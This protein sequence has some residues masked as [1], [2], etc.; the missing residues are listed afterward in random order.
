MW[1]AFSVAL[2]GI[3]PP[4]IDKSY[5]ISSS[6]LSFWTSLTSGA[7][8]KPTARFS[9]E[10]DFGDDNAAAALLADDVQFSDMVD[11]FSRHFK[12]S[13]C[14]PRR[15]RD[16]VHAGGVIEFEFDVRVLT[17]HS[18]SET[19]SIEGTAIERQFLVHIDTCEAP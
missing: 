17:G 1:P 10:G 9:Y 12:E 2:R 15:F 7:D 8:G 13:L 5:S 11:I 16:F 14:N 3:E 4:K 18:I 6:N 19:S